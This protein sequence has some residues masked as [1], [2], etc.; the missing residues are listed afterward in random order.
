MDVLLVGCGRMGGAMA[1]GW[2]G[3][4]RVL[5]FDPLAAELPEGA[6]RAGSLDD[7][8]AGG[9]LAVVLAVKPQVFP[10]IAESLR[11]LARA[12]ALFVSI[13]AGITLQGLS[14]ALGSGRAVRT[15]PNTPAAIGQGI[16]AAV[17]G[18]DVRMSDFATVNELLGPTGQVVWLDDEAQIDAVTA[19]SGSGPASYFFRF[20]EALAKAGT[21]E[22]LP[23]ALAMQLARAT[24][25]GAAALAGADPAELADLRRQVTSP[26]GTTAAGLGQMDQT[27]AIDRLVQSVVEAA[28]ARSR[29]LAG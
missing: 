23:P 27:D 1:R 19:V 13:M 28:A 5:V 26:G 3:A 2:Q 24:F 7:V 6:E 17:A 29:E 8:E 16:T 9:E 12:D 14:D 15:M 20:T 21:E 11:P 22:G 18:R 10:S 4:H 25:T